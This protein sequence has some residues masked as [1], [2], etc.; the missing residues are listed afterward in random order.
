M[1]Y[2]HS[3]RALKISFVRQLKIIKRGLI[4]IQKEWT[5]FENSNCWLHW[6]FT[7]VSLLIP[8]SL[9]VITLKLI[10]ENLRVISDEVNLPISFS[11]NHAH[12][13]LGGIFHHCYSSWN[14]KESQSVNWMYINFEIQIMKK[15]FS[16]RFKHGRTREEKEQK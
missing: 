6:Y 5:T 16:R 1:I 4:R 9:E 15:P 10:K 13:R 11:R 8:L 2:R 12:L 3:S 14:K 7:I